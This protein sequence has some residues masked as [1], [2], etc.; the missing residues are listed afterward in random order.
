[1][2]AVFRM[3][4]TRGVSPDERLR[5][6]IVD[7]NLDFVI[8]ASRLLA[9]QGIAVVGV[10][11]TI[12]EGLR[13]IENAKPAVILVDIDLGAENGFDLVEQLDRNGTSA[14]APV[15]LISTHAEEDF[16]DMVAGSSATAFVPK[17]DLSGD[18]IREALGI[19]E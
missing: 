14:V 1:M 15:I 12:S 5:C 8:A 9:H 10:A 13:C 19:P 2:W 7:D 3:I 6:V 17:S 18:T 16:A 11:H 4:H